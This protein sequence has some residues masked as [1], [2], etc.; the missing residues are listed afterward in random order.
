MKW[1]GVADYDEMSEYGAELIFRAVAAAAAEKR[2]FHLGLA[3]G[4]TMLTLYRLLAEKWNAARTDLSRLHTWNLDEYA[5][6]DGKAV[7][8]SHPLSYRRYMH[9]NLFGRI[10]PALG[11]DASRAHFPDPANPAAFDAAL[12]GAGG[13]D[14]QLLGIGF[15][16]HIAF[17]EPM[18]ESKI[19]RAEF[20]AL[21]S[22]LIAL[23]LLTVE[24]NRRLTAGGADI[25]PRHAA[26]MGM[27][28]ILGAKRLLLLGCFP[29]QKQPLEAIRS[30]RV[31]PELPA[32]YLLDAPDSEIVWTRDTID[33]P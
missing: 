26:T 12:A 15:N 17:N 19:T 13:L 18:P 7:P 6:P 28:Q 10:D 31:T 29:E 20:A 23:T 27:R 25:V 14:F 30:G 8:E 16:G 9:E 24:T 21:P 4:N 3:T 32:S 2:P 22:R 1:T 5:G 11:F 33:L